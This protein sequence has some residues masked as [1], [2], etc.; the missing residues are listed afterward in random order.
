M[1]AIFYL[2][3]GNLRLL[4]YVTYPLIVI[5]L[6]TFGLSLLIYDQLNAVSLSFA[7]IL[8]GTVDRLRGS[9]STAAWSTNGS[10]TAATWR[11]AITATLAGLGRANVAASATTAAGFAV[12]G[13]SV[14]SAVSQLGVLTAIGMA[15]TTLEFFTLYP[16][17][18]FLL[19][20]AAAQRA[21]QR[22]SGAPG[23]LRRAG[24]APRARDS[25]RA[26]GRRG[27][28]FIAGALRDAARSEPRQAAAGAHR[29][30]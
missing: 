3:Y 25:R 9:I 27:R 7:A 8:Y 14:L 16:A 29:R 18:G 10:A 11:G 21:A 2:G 23:A 6:I 17:L 1:L 26:D 5:T 30:R 13:F 19:G 4:P 24:A 28:C 15:V 20:S 22:G 12:I